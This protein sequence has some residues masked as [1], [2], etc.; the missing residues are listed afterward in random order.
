MPHDP[1]NPICH[2]PPRP[3]ICDVVGVRPQSADDPSIAPALL[4]WWDAQHAGATLDTETAW[5]RARPY[6]AGRTAVYTFPKSP[7]GFI[8]LLGYATPLFEHERSVTFDLSKA[9][10]GGGIKV[11]RPQRDVPGDPRPLT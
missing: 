1:T 7:E 5:K 11:I 4:A 9:H 3:C 6:F 10:H 2:H 8:D